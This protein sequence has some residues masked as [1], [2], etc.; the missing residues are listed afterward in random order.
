MGKFIEPEIKEIVYRMI[1]DG[2]SLNLISKETSLS[3][4]TIYY[5]Y[6]KLKGSV[7]QKVNMNLNDPEMLGE[8]LGIFAGDGYANVDR[9]Y[10]YM[11]RLFFNPKE[12]KYVER[13]EYLLFKL[14][15]KKPIKI[16]PKKVN[17]IILKYSS[18]DIFNL[19]SNYIT[20]TREGHGSKSRT[21]K[22]IRSEKSRDF[23]VGFLRGC[24]DSD[25][26]ISKNK[27]LFATSSEQLSKNISGF[28]NELGISF[29]FTINKDK[30]K[31]RVPVNILY[32]KKSDR[33]KFLNLIKPKNV[34]APIGKFG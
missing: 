22:L 14:F 33:E 5:H 7:I 6:N 27:I 9:E 1:R 18:K 28:L 30:R 25:G 15:R 3:K 26:Y 2:K 32:V 31:N 17:V 16:K 4:T 23:R 29:S 20:W 13:V 19:V 12:I 8:F 11:I 24:V 21:V 34:S 10:H